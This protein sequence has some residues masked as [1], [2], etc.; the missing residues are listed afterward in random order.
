[1]H[2]EVT[3]SAWNLLPH[4]GGRTQAPTHIVPPAQFLHTV[5]KCKFGKKEVK[6]I[7]L[8]QGMLKLLEYT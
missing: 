4:Y 1:M 2:Q 6:H 5:K 7:T 8:Y 3:L